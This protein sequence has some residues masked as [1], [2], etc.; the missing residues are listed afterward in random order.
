MIVPVYNIIRNTQPMPI[1]MRGEE[2]GEGGELWFGWGAAWRDCAGC[3]V[4]SSFDTFYAFWD[5]CVS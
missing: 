2:V 1:R 3:R 4:T 5:F